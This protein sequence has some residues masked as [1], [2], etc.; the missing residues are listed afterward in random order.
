MR[1]IIPISVRGMNY[2]FTYFWF[3]FKFYSHSVIVDTYGNVKLGNFW[4]CRGIDDVTT[5]ISEVSERIRWL[6][7]E[8]VIDGSLPYSMEADVYRYGPVPIVRGNS[9]AFRLLLLIDTE[10]T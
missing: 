9:H 1:Y 2:V 10:R 3:S 6:C 8:K 5:S 4:R 7:P